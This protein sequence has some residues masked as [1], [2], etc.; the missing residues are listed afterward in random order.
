[1]GLKDKPS[2]SELPQF[3]Q[4]SYDVTGAGQAKERE[5]IGRAQQ[6]LYTWASTGSAGVASR[7]G[8]AVCLCW[9]MHVPSGTNLLL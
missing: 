8:A 6:S 7:S 4:V 1:M 2:L 9:V 5:M 3:L